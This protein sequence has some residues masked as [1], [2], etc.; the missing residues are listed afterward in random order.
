MATL[1]AQTTA[2]MPTNGTGTESDPYEIENLANLRWLSETTSEWSKHFVQMADIDATETANWNEGE[3]FSPIG[4]DE[5]NS[6]TGNYNGNFH[7]ISNLYIYRPND[8]YQGLFGYQIKSITNLILENVDITGKDYVGGIAGY[9]GYNI[10]K[11][12][13]SGSVKGNR[14]VG[15]ISGSGR[16]I[17][18]SFSE[19][20]I[21]GDIGVGGISGDAR[22]GITRILN[23]YSRATISGRVSVAGIIGEGPD[24]EPDWGSAGQVNYNYF[25]GIIENATPQHSG[26][27]FGSYSTEA[28]QYLL[29]F[30]FW[31]KDL[32][33][34]DWGTTGSAYYFTTAEMK[35]TLTYLSG[36]WEM[37]SIRTNAIWDI[38][39]EINDGYPYLVWTH[40]I[41]TQDAVEPIVGNGSEENPYQIANLANLRW[42]YEN[43]DVWDKYFIQTA[44]IDAKE[45]KYWE[46]RNRIGTS[47]TNFTGSYNGNFNII[48]NL[49]IELFGVID[50]ATIEKVV[51]TNALYANYDSAGGIVDYAKN[52]KISQTSFSGII[53]SSY[54]LGGICGTN[55]NT[56]IEESFS[57]GAIYGKIECIGGIVGRNY[58]GI[59]KNNYSTSSLSASKYDQ[60]WSVGGIIGCHESES[61]I[62]EYN[63]FAGTFENRVDNAKGIIAYVYSNAY[64]AVDKGNLWDTDISQVTDNLGNGIG[65]SSSEMKDLDTYTDAMW[66]LKYPNAENPAWNIGNGKNNGYPYLNWQYPD[67][68][69]IDIPQYAFVDFD[70]I[71]LIGI[72]TVEGQLNVIYIGNPVA[73]EFGICYTIGGTPT[74][75]D[76][77]VTISSAINIGQFAFEITD[78]EE[79]EVY[80]FRAYA[81]N[82]V[83][84]SYGKEIVK[85]ILYSQVPEGDGTEA[86]P[87]LISNFN[88]LYWVSENSDSWDKHFLQTADIDAIFSES[89]LSAQGGLSPI[90]N[91][92]KMFTGRYN[93]N[94]KTISNLIINRPNTDYVGLFGYTNSAT[95]EKLSYKCGN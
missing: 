67:D 3:G 79:G 94:Y 92:S 52:S 12:S 36:Y 93:G 27:I 20:Y 73:T 91:D 51:V 75:S 17:Y 84:T 18:E 9:G 83:G 38:N 56:I 40:T 39:S 87:Y 57:D 63:Y 1:F 48:D 14:Y 55:K 8:D 22:S 16:G 24:C 71:N 47:Q 26:A 69:Y 11:T 54:N 23:C 41:E 76:E 25:A 29:G 78:L 33:G 81:I 6:F 80:S 35:N 30:N 45:A 60:V 28:Q 53:Y 2:V 32:T 10:E 66:L 68:D 13:V 74:T 59:I 43:E 62:I 65:L 5:E 15:G 4:I 61:A 72:N 95:I 85:T 37:L 89:A 44:D 64:P 21:E 7:K 82:E 19:G 49:T 90:G 70:E 46:R 86:N 58:D 50:N 88:E 34:I 31:E 77:T 42:L